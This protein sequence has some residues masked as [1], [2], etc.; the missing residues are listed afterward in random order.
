MKIGISGAGGQLGKAVL[1]ELKARGAN[2]TI[3]GISRTPETVSS[4]VEGRPGDYDRPETLVE[5]YDGLDRLLIIPGHDVRPGVR[6]RQFVAAINAEAAEP[7]MY[8]PYWTGEQHLL[9]TAPRW[10]ILRMNYYA[11]SFAQVTS[12]SLS[13]NATGPVAVTGAER[14][15]HSFP[16]SRESLCALPCSMK[17][18]F[19]A[20]SY[21]P[22]YPKNTS[23]PWLISKCASWR[24]TSI[25][26]QATS[27]ASPAAGRDRLATS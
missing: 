20:D 15:Q 8:A 9:K 27:S 25:S 24:V 17:R 12:M 16:K 26:S 3:V 22:V 14:A 7:E 19:A 11:E 13:Y 1:A 10:T 2:H 18:S 6:S 23:T 5:A 21:R 4:P